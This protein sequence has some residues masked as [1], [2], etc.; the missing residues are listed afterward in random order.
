MIKVAKDVEEIKEGQAV[1]ID[2]DWYVRPAI[3]KLKYR[4]DVLDEKCNS[5]WKEKKK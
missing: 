5:P 3:K 1:F 2:T 4:Q